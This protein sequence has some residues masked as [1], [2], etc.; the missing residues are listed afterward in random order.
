MEYNFSTVLTFWCRSK[1]KRYTEVSFW[2][3]HNRS[4]TLTFKVKKAGIITVLSLIWP[5]PPIN[6]TMQSPAGLFWFLRLI[7]VPNLAT[8]WYAC[9]VIE[10]R[11][12]DWSILWIFNKRNYISRNFTQH[13][14]S[15]QFILLKT[16][17]WYNLSIHTYQKKKASSIL[18]FL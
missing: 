3:D 7:T 13:H 17:V 18:E 14:V 2:H 15:W 4:E 1:V 5:L 11:Q 12:L 6:P 16:Q 9:W 8:R 10:V